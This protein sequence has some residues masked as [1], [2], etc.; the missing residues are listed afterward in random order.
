MKEKLIKF[1]IIL[2]FP[3]LFVFLKD[4]FQKKNI[5]IP[6]HSYGL[7]VYLTA[8]ATGFFAYYYSVYVTRIKP[9]L[10]VEEEEKSEDDK[11]EDDDKEEKK[12]EVDM[13]DEEERAKIVEALEGNEGSAN[14]EKGD[15]K[16]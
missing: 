2:L 16:K 1:S 10:P 11:E 7:A 12:E 3:A 14:D 8:I 5:P 6:D 15:S 9:F 13:D 4:L